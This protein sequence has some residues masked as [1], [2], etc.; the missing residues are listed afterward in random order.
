MYGPEHFIHHGIFQPPYPPV[1]LG[2]TPPA[3]LFN[4]KDD[5]LEQS[6]LAA[7]DPDRVARLGLELDQWF[8]DV[9]RDRRSIADPVPPSR[10]PRPWDGQ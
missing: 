3:L 8:D 6:D 1:D 4:I 9:E 7:A 5:P 10:T 2:P